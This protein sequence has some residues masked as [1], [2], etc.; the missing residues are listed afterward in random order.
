SPLL[1]YCFYPTLSQ[2]LPFAEGDEHRITLG[3][4]A[5]VQKQVS[6]NQERTAELLLPHHTRCEMS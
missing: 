3:G 5:L 2:R 1:D 4:I 6:A